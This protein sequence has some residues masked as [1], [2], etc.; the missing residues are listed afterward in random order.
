MSLT[1][2][3]YLSI[4]LFLLMFSIMFGIIIITNVNANTKN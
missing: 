2:S 1:N 3:E 4:I